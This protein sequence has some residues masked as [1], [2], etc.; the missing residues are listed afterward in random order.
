MADSSLG[1]SARSNAGRLEGIVMGKKDFLS[2]LEKRDL[3]SQMAASSEN[4]LHWGEKYEQAGRVADAIDFYTKAG[5]KDALSR[6]LD[7]ARAEGD[8]FLMRRLHHALGSVA[9]AE[10]WLALARKAEELGKFAFAAEAYRLGGAVE[11]M[12]RI[13]SPS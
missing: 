8:L 12:E 11:D 6:L 5:A 9:H 1:V 3:M 4:L 13:M 2:C 7:K 10:E